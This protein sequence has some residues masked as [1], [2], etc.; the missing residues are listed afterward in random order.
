MICGYISKVY[1]R[2][3]FVKFVSVQQI[4]GATGL[5]VFFKITECFSYGLDPID[6]TNGHLLVSIGIS[7]LKQVKRVRAN[8]LHPI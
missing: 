8:I 6:L 2:T 1:F 5:A 4:L 7:L 3:D